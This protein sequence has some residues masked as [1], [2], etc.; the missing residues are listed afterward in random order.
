MWSFDFFSF[1]RAVC[2]AH[3]ATRQEPQR[4][5]HLILDFALTKRRAGK[6]EM[7]LVRK[8]GTTASQANRG[9]SVNGSIAEAR[10][11]RYNT[12]FSHYLSALTHSFPD[13]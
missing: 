4:R 13:N 11:N 12:Q 5:S 9:K 1:W 3:S 6:A 2:H 10:E 8:S 7:K